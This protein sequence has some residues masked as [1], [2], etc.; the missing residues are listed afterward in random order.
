MRRQQL[1]TISLVAAAIFILL[2]MKKAST[3]SEGQ[4]TVYGTK[5]CGWTVKQLNYM[6][7]NEKSFRFIDCE[8]EKCSGMTG[9]P[10]LVSPEGERIM[11][12]TEI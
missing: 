12:Y 8:K 10:T 9:F 4:W 3:S 5:G 2:R 6:Q 1:I 7:K 11:G